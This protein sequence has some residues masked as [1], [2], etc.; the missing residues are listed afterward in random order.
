MAAGL[1]G[2]TKAENGPSS[3]RLF[4]RFKPY[5][6]WSVLALLALVLGFLAP[7]LIPIAKR[8]LLTNSESQAATPEDKVQVEQQFVDFDPTRL[9]PLLFMPLALFGALWL[10]RGRLFGKAARPDEDGLRTLETLALGHRCVIYLIQAGDAELLAGMDRGGLKALIAVPSHFENTLE[11]AAESAPSGD[12]LAARPVSRTSSEGI[13]P[14]FLARF[15]ELLAARL[16][17]RNE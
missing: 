5:L 11:E 7:E 8:E 10:L 1:E 6:L 14:A 17:R 9:A 15:Q 13:D 3:A 2:Q 16:E 12:V 4:D